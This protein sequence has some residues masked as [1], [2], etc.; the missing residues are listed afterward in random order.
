[1]SSKRKSLPTKVLDSFIDNGEL[2]ADNEESTVHPLLNT[3]AESENSGSPKYNYGISREEKT[4]LTT[5]PVTTVASPVRWNDMD[6]NI[7]SGINAAKRTRIEGSTDSLDEFSP[8][9][10]PFVNPFLQARM[11][12]EH[13]RLLQE[14]A[15]RQEQQQKQ[16]LHQQHLQQ[17]QVQQQQ[18]QQIPQ[19]QSQP[20]SFP[21]QIG[22]NSLSPVSEMDRAGLLASKRSMDDVLKRLASKMSHSSIEDAER[23]RHER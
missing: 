18:Q 8:H 4:Q 14:A 2:L 20:Q 3:P 7:E 17:Q 13:A 5:T 21:P 19:Q 9:L 1:M 12:H 10:H 23:M 15:V 16:H 22:R 11:Q 6:S